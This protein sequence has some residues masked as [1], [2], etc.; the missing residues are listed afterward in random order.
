MKYKFIDIGCGPFDVSSDIYGT[1]VKGMY[2]EPIKQFLDILPGSNSIDKVNAAITDF[3]GER[4]MD[5]WLLDEPIKYYTKDELHSIKETIDRKGIDIANTGLGRIINSGGGTFIENRDSIPYE[6][7][8]VNVKCI[9][10]KKLINDYNI[11]E[12]DHI[13]IDVEG[14]ENIVLNQLL[15]IMRSTDFKINNILQFEW[16]DLSDRDEL[17]KLAECFANEFNFK[18]T[19]LHKYWNEDLI[20]IK[21]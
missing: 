4:E 13:K 9:T 8:K 6:S 1:N 16:N 10:L 7:T 21:Q 11:E 20:L 5:V 18:I 3:I 17:M 14:H 15:D 19:H 2:I 12:V